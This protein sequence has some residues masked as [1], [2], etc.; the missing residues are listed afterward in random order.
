VTFAEASIPLAQTT[1][2][3]ALPLSEQ[4]GCAA[5]SWGGAIITNIPSIILALLIVAL[6]LFLDD[7]AQRAVERIVGANV[8]QR[9]L[10]RL[11]GRMARFGVLIVALL[12]ILA[13]FELTAL[14]TSFVASLGIAGLLIAFALQDITKNFAAGILLSV[15]RPFS[16]D[17]RIK[18]KDFEGVVTDISLR[19][20]TLRTSEGLEVLV[21]NADVYTSP[22][23]NFTRH[24]HRRYH[25]PISVP[26]SLP[27]EPMRQQLEAALRA[28][29]ELQGNPLPEVVVTAFNADNITLEARYWL[30]SVAPKA[31]Q[32]TTVVIEQLQQ[33]VQTFAAAQPVS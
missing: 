31:P 1:N 9:V 15:L 13:L 24:P 12:I 19:A 16:L 22:I 10:A 23:T 4:W 32:I 8:N 25:I 14:V 20:T 28:L 5:K 3:R 11:L 21:P 33:H 26:A 30:P 7:R 27:I 18:V 2:C 29:P 17:D 6:A